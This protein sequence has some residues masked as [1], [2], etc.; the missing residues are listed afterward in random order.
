MTE[1]RGP[2][3]ATPHRVERDP[4]R[5]AFLIPGLAYSTERPLLHFARAVFLRHGWTTQEI[6]WPEQPP[7]PG[8]QPF[9][10]WFAQLRAFV[11][12]HV[13]PLLAAEAAPRIAL[14]GKS[15]GAFAAA[16]AADRGLPAIWLTPVLRG[17]DLAIDLRRS[18][19]PF[20]LVGGT[21]DPS[22]DGELAHG[23][24][25]PVCEVEGADHGMETADDPVNSAEILRRTT[26]AM[27]EFVARL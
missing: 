9:P 23:L 2:R 14:A 7:Q 21:S 24:G 1:T 19:A 4:D 18:T 10:L 16:A 11:Q 5:V 3:P 6:R 20:L 22:W 15:M 17:T 13:G 27:D 26:V 25:G 8:D 12:A